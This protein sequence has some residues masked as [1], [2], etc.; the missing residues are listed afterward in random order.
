MIEKVTQKFVWRHVS[1][2]NIHEGDLNAR[3]ANFYIEKFRENIES[4]MFFF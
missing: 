2:L 1:R 4:R 3:I